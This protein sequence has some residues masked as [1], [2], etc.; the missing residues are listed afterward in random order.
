LF[1]ITY[2]TL[3]PSIDPFRKNPS[4]NHVEQKQ[5][6]A[7]EKIMNLRAKLKAVA[8]Q[9]NETFASLLK[10]VKSLNKEQLENLLLV[11]HGSEKQL[12]KIELMK[13]EI[14]ENTKKQMRDMVEETANSALEEALSKAGYQLVGHIKKI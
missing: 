1:C 7:K 8:Q 11:G 13:I 9:Q 6:N 2:P 14:R 3:C 4:I 10:K 5:L 12:A